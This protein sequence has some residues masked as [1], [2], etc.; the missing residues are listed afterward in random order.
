VIKTAIILAGGLGTRLR[1]TIPNIPKPMAPI[2]NRPFLEHQMDYLIHQGIRK[3]ILSVGYLNHIIINHFGCKYKNAS[4]EY[5]IEDAPL[6]TG[7]G[8]ILALKNQTEAVLVI[9]GDTFFEVNLMELTSFHFIR[10]SQLTL[11]LFRTNPI[12]R[13]MGVEMDS[14]G[15]ILTLKSDLKLPSSSNLVNGGLYIIEPSLVSSFGYKLG[16]K[17]SFEDDILSKLLD[18]NVKLFGKEF[19]GVFIDI[20]IPK[21]Y[22]RAQELLN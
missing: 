5:T 1:D 10:K 8:L 13:Y 16:Q 18:S 22:Y 9:N 20:G 4:I 2:N 19:K 6:G 17:F 7:G 11:S 14:N 21:D 15:E 3:F 12:K